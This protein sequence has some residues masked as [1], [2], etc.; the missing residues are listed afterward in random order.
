MRLLLSAHPAIRSLWQYYLKN[1]TGWM[2]FS[3]TEE[4]ASPQTV[5]HK[6]REHCSVEVNHYIIDWV[7]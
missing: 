7:R 3:G 6:V 2:T 4:D 5:L 1:A